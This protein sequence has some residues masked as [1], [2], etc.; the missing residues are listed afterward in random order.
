MPANS[1]TDLALLKV[2]VERG[3]VG[4]LMKQRNIKNFLEQF[5]SSMELVKKLNGEECHIFE[6][7]ASFGSY[8][9]MIGPREKNM[10]QGRE[11]RPIEINGA[12][13]HLYLTPNHVKAHPSAREIDNSLKD[14]VIMRDLTIH[15]KDPTGS[16]RKVDSAVKRYAVTAKEEINLAGQAG[17]QLK[18]RM[19]HTGKLAK[20]AYKIIQEDIL[21]AVHEKQFERRRM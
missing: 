15:I 12:M 8:Q 6:V 9:I 21:R 7:H 4:G 16:G 20:D 1:G 17:E 18:T 10:R 11:V 3:E 19:I 14:C 2:R 5:L 13:H